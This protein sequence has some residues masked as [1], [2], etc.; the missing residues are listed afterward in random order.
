MWIWCLS[1]LPSLFFKIL[2]RK[3]KC[4]ETEGIFD[5][6]PFRPEIVLLNVGDLFNQA[7]NVLKR[8][9]IVILQPWIRCVCDVLT[10]RGIFALWGLRRIVL[11]IPYVCLLIKYIFLLLLVFNSRHIWCISHDAFQGTFLSTS[12]YMA[13][14]HG[15][16]LSARHL[17]IFS[18]RAVYE[19]VFNLAVQKCMNVLFF[20][21]W[22]NFKLVSFV[23]F[24]LLRFFLYCLFF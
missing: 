10:Q 4:S 6:C 5:S 9:N 3:A 19:L 18:T 17:W 12:A 15:P 20:C 7:N 14:W 2:Y 24:F 21:A 11:F 13:F 23:S 16:I 22:F 1:A 8:S